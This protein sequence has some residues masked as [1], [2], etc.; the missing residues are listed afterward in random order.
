MI[1]VSSSQPSSCWR[2]SPS[3]LL[4]FNG[5]VPQSSQAGPGDSADG[6]RSTSSSATATPCARLF[7]SVTSA[8]T[9][10]AST[11]G[12]ELHGAAA[13]VLI[14]DQPQRQSSAGSAVRWLTVPQLSQLLM[15]STQVDEVD[16]SM[17]RKTLAPVILLG[18][19][20]DLPVVSNV[21]Q[22]SYLVRW[23]SV[24]SHP[25]QHLLTL[26]PPFF[27][28]GVVNP[29]V[30]DFPQQVTNGSN[31]LQ[32]KAQE[33]HLVDVLFDMAHIGPPFAG[34]LD[35]IP[36]MSDEAL[37]LYD[38]KNVELIPDQQHRYGRI[39]KRNGTGI[40]QL[41][42]TFLRAKAGTRCHIPPHE[43]VVFFTAVASDPQPFDANPPSLHPPILNPLERT[44]LREGYTNEQTHCA[45]SLAAV[46]FH[47]LSQTA[48]S[49]QT[50]HWYIATH[51]TNKADSDVMTV[52]VTSADPASTNSSSTVTTSTPP[53]P[54][55]T[56]LVYRYLSNDLNVL[57][58]VSPNNTLREQNIMSAVSRSTH[59]PTL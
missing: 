17:W 48:V 26:E 56:P 7:S 36:I 24:G 21:S 27:S 42:V 45:A 50:P 1:S 16:R 55:P 18:F 30:N 53:P 22:V 25:S 20:Q 14:H 39:G 59:T 51:N 29:F 57:S 54:P 9:Q 52:F 33:L 37:A 6:H 47:H 38:R 15:D 41:H 44:V 8:S 23:G 46:T 35:H 11:G 49:N 34:L 12:D 32:P 40:V 5:A 4:D 2:P 43:P 10:S 19:H 13:S 31:S 58:S 3:Q 28:S